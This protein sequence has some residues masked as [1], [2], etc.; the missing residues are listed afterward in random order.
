V[1]LGRFGSAAASSAGII[2]AELQ[3]S[4]RPPWPS[5]LILLIVAEHK[6]PLLHRRHPLRESAQPAGTM[7]AAPS[8]QL[9]QGHKRGGVSNTVL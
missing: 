9:K 5:V 4:F 7:R 8:E 2:Q 3:T 1:S 6:A